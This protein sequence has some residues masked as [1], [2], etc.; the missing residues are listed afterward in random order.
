MTTNPTASISPQV[1]AYLSRL[2]AAVESADRS[3]D[4]DLAGALGAVRNHL[5][6]L[7]VGAVLGPA[8]V[9][10]VLN[11]L[12]HAVA[13]AKTIAAHHLPLT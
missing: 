12:G 6:D 13:E 10:A 4:V 1:D 7:H 9:I 2:D 11:A 5:E 8:D 3:G